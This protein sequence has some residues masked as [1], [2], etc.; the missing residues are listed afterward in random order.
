MFAAGGQSVPLIALCLETSL[1][2][3][4]L[5]PFACCGE[6]FEGSHCCAAVGLLMGSA[7]HR[8]TS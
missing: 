6:S 1:H 4:V 7:G 8:Q 2:Y 5:E 3:R